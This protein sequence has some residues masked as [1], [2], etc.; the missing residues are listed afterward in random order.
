M[1]IT[2][3][4]PFDPYCHMQ[5]KTTARSGRREAQSP[6]GYWAMKKSHWF[7]NALKSCALLLAIL[8]AALIASNALAG[9]K[10]S[11]VYVAVVAALLVLACSPWAI[12]RFAFFVKQWSRESS[13]KNKSYGGSTSASINTPVEP[14]ALINNEAKELQKKA[15]EQRLANLQNVVKKRNSG[16]APVK[17]R[18]ID[19]PSAAQWRIKRYM[20]AK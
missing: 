2:A 17:M 7:L 5:T 4:L 8:L 6:E 20:R 13:A 15:V 19:R 16:P 3:R 11:Y 1:R 10:V 12:P 9:Q 14:H 18:Y